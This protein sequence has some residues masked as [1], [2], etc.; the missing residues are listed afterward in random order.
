MTRRCRDL[1]NARVKLVVTFSAVLICAVATIFLGYFEDESVIYTHFYYV[2]VVLAA[3]W[4]RRNGLIV[5]SVLVAF[6]FLSVGA[7]ARGLETNDYLR[8]AVVVVVGF[9]VGELSNM[10]STARME[11]SACKERLQKL[12]EVRTAELN[13]ANAKLA[14]MSRITRH[15][16]VN[17]LSVLS[18]WLEIAS[19]SKD[20]AECRANLGRAADAGRAMRIAFEFAAEY[21]RIGAKAP[22][23]VNLRTAFSSGVSGLVL[24]GAE[25]VDGLP[26]CEVHADPMLCKVFGN[27][28]DNS[29]RHG[30]GIHKISVSG[31]PVDD[32][33]VLEYEDDGTGI[34]DKDRVHLFEPG[35]GRHTGLGLHFSKRV[36]DITGISIEERGKSGSGVRFVI[37]VPPGKWRR[38]DG[39][40]PVTGRVKCP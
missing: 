11:L 9:V 12:V 4:Y 26:D 29:L 28:V 10:S 3:L 27:L 14:L 37:T 31:A 25:V 39:T 32:S 16:L 2:P 35:Y 7:S 20:M 18:G 30:G 19:E 15:D 23:W 33:L 24:G 34:S 6:Y 40:A 36:L 5:P 22:V 21:E 17:D 8:G 38:V 13:D 1:V